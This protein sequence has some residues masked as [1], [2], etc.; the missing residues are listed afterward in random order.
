MVRKIDLQLIL[1]YRNWKIKNIWRYLWLIDSAK[2]FLKK[3]LIKTISMIKCKWL[4]WS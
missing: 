1:E 4:I 3:I 2:T